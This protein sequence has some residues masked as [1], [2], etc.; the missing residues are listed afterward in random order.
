MPALVPESQ[1]SCDKMILD[2]IGKSFDGICVLSD[3]SFS[4]RAGEVLSLLGENGAGKSTLSSI[5]A[6]IH[7]ADSGKMIWNGQLY[8]PSSPKEAMHSGIGL[9]HQETNLL[10]ELSI[11]ENIFLGRLICNKGLIDKKQMR[12][13]ADEQLSS[14]GLHMASDTNV[15][16][17]RVAEMQ[18]VEIAKALIQDSRLLILD[19]PTASLSEE[20]AELLFTLIKKLQQK[21]VSFIYISHRLDEIKRIAKPPCKKSRKLMR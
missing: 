6:G 9:I 11:Y 13:L 1:N 8:A 2:N 17:L 20:E 4:V 19:E 21:G 3:I 18:M 5:I 7:Q 14:L 16:K 10:P 12:K 15:S